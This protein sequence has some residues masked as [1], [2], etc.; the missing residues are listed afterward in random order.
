MSN[1]VVRL[2]H[3]PRGMV[4]REDSSIEDRLL[5]QPRAGEV[6]VGTAFVS[7]DPAMRGWM[8][9]G[10]SYLPSVA[11]GEGMRACAAGYVDKSNNAS[12]QVGDAVLGAHS[13]SHP[14]TRRLV[15]RGQAQDPRGVREGGGD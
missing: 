13:R 9:E 11:I 12:F 14:A 10:R 3:R 6:R 15:R 7:L 4:T 5:P 2:A 8:A 1:R